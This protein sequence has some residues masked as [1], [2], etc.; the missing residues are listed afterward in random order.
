MKTTGVKKTEHQVRREHED[1]L[2]RQI[3]GHLDADP[4]VAAAELG[5]LALRKFAEAY[6]A[7]GQTPD[8]RRKIREN[9]PHA[10]DDLIAER[11]MSQHG[12]LA[13]LAL[14]EQLARI[15]LDY[16]PLSHCA[17]QMAHDD[18][19]GEQIG[20]VTSGRIHHAMQAALDQGMSPFGVACTGILSATMFGRSIGVPYPLLARPLIDALSVAMPG[21]S[22]SSP[23]SDEDIIQFL[24]AQMGFGRAAA[25]KYLQLAK[26]LPAEF[27]RR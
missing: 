5:A 27:F 7:T 26:D 17:P 24:M 13:V 16:S 22:D 6:P 4:A 11:A 2:L 15:A 3:E 9:Y 20:T 1:A 12:L 23:L 21:Q 25:K 14:S 19:M 10:T 8:D 18:A